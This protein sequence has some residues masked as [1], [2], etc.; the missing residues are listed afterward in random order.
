MSATVAADSYTIHK[1]P[2][3]GFELKLPPNAFP[4]SPIPTAVSIRDHLRAGIFAAGRAAPGMPAHG[5]KWCN[6]GILVSHVDPSTMAD[7]VLGRL[8]ENNWE[9]ANI[10]VNT[11]AVQYNGGGLLELQYFRDDFLPFPYAPPQPL[12]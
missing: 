2:T 3:G 1:L 9:N 4:S 6:Y 11:L 8:Q 10:F 7:H 12:A 5:M